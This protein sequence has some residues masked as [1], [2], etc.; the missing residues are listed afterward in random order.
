MGL[1]GLTDEQQEQVD[2][3][4]LLYYARGIAVA[5]KELAKTFDEVGLSATTAAKAMQELMEESAKI[6][7]EDEAK[8]GK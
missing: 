6:V 7:E 3:L 2:R 4:L 1:E 8:Y 5:V